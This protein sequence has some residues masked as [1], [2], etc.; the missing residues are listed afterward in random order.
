MKKALVAYDFSPYAR[1][2][3]GLAMQGYPFGQDIELEVL[4]IVDERL[5]ESTLSRHAI[6]SD[7]AI[8][9]YFRA[10]VERVEASLGSDGKCRVRPKLC[11]RRGHPY[12]VLL[13]QLE[14]NQACGLWI[15]GQG[16]GGISETILGRT[17]RRILHR[18]SCSVYVTKQRESVTLPGLALCAVDL[19]PTSEAAL[20]E[21]HRI[22]TTFR[23]PFSVIHILESNYAPYLQQLVAS[24][25]LA[26]EF[27]RLRVMA[28]DDLIQFEKQALG[29]LH[30]HSRRVVIGNPRQEILNEAEALL[31]GTIVVGCHGRNTLG[32]A[33][34]GSVAEGL[35]DRSDKDVYVVR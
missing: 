20:R 33:L 10:E 11:V 21:T 6:P 15:G 25:K 12:E 26:D 23:F 14:K 7:A 1:R 31:A 34:L 18:S 17:V 27:D 30:A 13:D 4:H 24:E 29:A 5:Y 28:A 16:H 19:H 22:A 2:A 3:L 35:L 9:A 8:E 32:R